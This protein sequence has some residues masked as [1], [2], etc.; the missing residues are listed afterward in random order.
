MEMIDKGRFVKLV[1]LRNILI[2]VSVICIILTMAFPSLFVGS[3]VI[4]AVTQTDKRI[5]SFLI[6][7][8]ADY[9]AVS[10]CFRLVRCLWNAKRYSNVFS[11]CNQN[12]STQELAIKMRKT[13]LKCIKELQEIIKYRVYWESAYYANYNTFV[14]NNGRYKVYCGNPEN[15]FNQF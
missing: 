1:L 6:F 12:T 5:P 8:I 13:N 11:T 7:L 14:I 10:R 9:F 3:K 2:G 4:T 15:I